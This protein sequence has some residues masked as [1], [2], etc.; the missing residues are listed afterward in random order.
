MW[1]GNPLAFLMGSDC[2]TYAAV[3]SFISGVIPPMSILGPLYRF[4]DILIQPLVPRG[5]I[6]AF[7]ICVLLSLARLYVL[8]RDPVLF[9][10]LLQQSTVVFGAVF[11]TNGL[12][13]AAPFDDLVQA[14]HHADR[15]QGK[16]NL[17]PQIFTVKNFQ[18]IQCSKG[19]PVA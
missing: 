4:N 17:D 11:D 16:I 5:A 7:E 8:D 10:L 19:L 13:F 18:N 9:G 6:E 3:F 1:K 14:V 15:R 2:R 12:G